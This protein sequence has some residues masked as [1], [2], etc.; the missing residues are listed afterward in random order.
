MTRRDRPALP[1]APADPD[2]L[3]GFPRWRLR[4]DRRLFRAHTA[5]LGPWWFSSDGSG[6]FDLEPPFGTCYLATDVETALRERFGHELIEFGLVSFGAAATTVVSR[7]HVRPG[8]TIADL[9]HNDA[10][11]YRVTREIGTTSD[12]PRTAGWAQALHAAGSSGV[13]YLSRFTT[14]TVGFA[15][16]LFGPA[17][18]DD[19]AATDP[20]PIAGR[21]ACM[22]IGVLV[23]HPPRLS[24]VRVITPER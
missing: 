19:A 17:G 16:A 3:E 24:Q 5:D 13:R 18:H 10:A 11:R 21:D 7:V 1:P 9:S 14:G 22:S 6:R 15:I 4:P 2:E 23:A 20:D 12:Y 8:R